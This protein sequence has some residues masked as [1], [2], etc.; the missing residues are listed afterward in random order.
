MRRVKVTKSKHIETGRIYDYPMVN[1][2]YELLFS[3]AM[4]HQF[5]QEGCDGEVY[6][7]AVIEYLGGK[8]ETVPVPAITFL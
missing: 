1:E 2:K 4:F 7:V 5:M 8:V 3:Q 6:V